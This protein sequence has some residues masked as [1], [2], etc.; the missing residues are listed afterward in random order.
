LIRYVVYTGAMRMPPIVSKEAAREAGLVVAGEPLAVDLAD[1]IKTLVEPPLDLIRDAERNAIFWQIEQH[2]LPDG[3]GAA[4]P[5]RT[6]ELRAAIRRLFDAKV[7]GGPFDPGALELVNG[8]A[9][10]AVAHPELVTTGDTAVSQV[11]WT[12]ETPGALALA[13]AA[14][15]AIEVLTGPNAD[16]LRRCASPTCSMFFVALNAKRQWCTPEGCGNRE[17][18]ARHARAAVSA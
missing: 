14:R 13:V 15:S 8:L 17:R 7:D 3:A 18:V 16:R 1:T 2:Q 10:T 4:D 5:Q 11:R 6:R 9:A 12:A